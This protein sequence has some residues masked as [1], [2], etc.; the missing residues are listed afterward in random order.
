VVL[1]VKR[2]DVGSTNDAYAQAYLGDDAAIAADAITVHPYL[3][4][5]AMGT[6]V[7]RAHQAGACLLVVT[8]S[9]NAEGRAIQAARTAGG[10]PV[11]QWLLTEIGALNARLAPGRVGPVGAVVG[12]APDLPALDLKAANA[13]YLVPGIG[14]QGAIPADVAA[15]FAACP[16]RVMPSASRS[17]LAA[18]PDV[19]ALGQAAAALNARFRE[20]LGG[21]R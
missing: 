13:L 21:Y 6:Y 20:V 7:D 19:A 15:T 18:G 10:A 2:G 9:S 8:R 3:G 1:D 5:A 4:L 16:E 11:E 17:L 12:S 14:A